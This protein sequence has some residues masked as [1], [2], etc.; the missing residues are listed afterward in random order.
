LNRIVPA[1]RRDDARLSITKVRGARI[2]NERRR[3]DSCFGGDD[4]SFDDY[5]V[6]DAGILAI[7]VPAKAG[8]QCLFAERR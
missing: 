8:T 6:R 4:A 3:M 5:E 7:V 1:L 2:L